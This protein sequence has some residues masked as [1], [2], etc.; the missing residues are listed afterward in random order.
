[1]IR[2]MQATPARAT[3]THPLR[4]P[5]TLIV[6]LAAL[7]LAVSIGG[8][9]IVAAPLTLFVLYRRSR[10]HR[11]GFFRAMIGVIGALTAA[12]LAWGVVY[13]VAGDAEPKPWIWLMP[14]IAATAVI[15]ASVKIKPRAGV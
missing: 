12:E 4:G 15:M 8:E 13:K 10:L 3:E 11:L 6:C 2:G 7:V 14:M 1:M 5:L 9:G